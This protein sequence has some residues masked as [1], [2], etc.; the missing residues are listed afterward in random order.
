M[1][2]LSTVSSFA[3]IKDSEGNTLGTIGHDVITAAD[4]SKLLMDWSA[5]MNADLTEDGTCQFSGGTGRFE[6]ATGSGTIHA[7]LTPEY[8]IVL[9]ITGTICY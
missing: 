3:D 9:I 6:D 1:G 5:T 7:Y 2:L 4:G 8:D